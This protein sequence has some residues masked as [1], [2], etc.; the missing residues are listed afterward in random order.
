MTA[1]FSVCTRAA[2][3]LLQTLP[4]PVIHEKG[5]QERRVKHQINITA[6]SMDIQSERRRLLDAEGGDEDPTGLMSEQDAYLRSVNVRLAC[7]AELTG[8]VT[9]DVATVAND[10]LNK[11]NRHR[12]GLL[13]YY[14]GFTCLC[15]FKHTHKQRSTFLLISDQY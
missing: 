14:R 12:D 11:T 6:V 15:Q 2:V 7:I 9:A 4:W 13:K 5:E 1:R 10:D 8:R 3:D